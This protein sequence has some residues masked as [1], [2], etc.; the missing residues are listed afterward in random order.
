MTV[1]ILRG[2]LLWC[3][4]INYATLVLWAA[5]TVWAPR[6]VHLPCRWYRLSAEQI[7]AINFGGLLLFKLGIFL[8]NLVP[9]VALRIVA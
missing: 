9:Y 2:A 5:L 8:F 3:G 6:L 7:D 1:E 4:I